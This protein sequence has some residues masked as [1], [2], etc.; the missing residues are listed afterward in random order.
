M[1]MCDRVVTCVEKKNRLAARR[2]RATS[3]TRCAGL[4]RAREWVLTPPARI[5]PP[6]RGNISMRHSTRHGLLGHFN[7]TPWRTHG[8][9]AGRQVRQRHGLLGAHVMDAERIGA[10]ARVHSQIVRSAIYRYDRTAVP[11]PL[12][13]IGRPARVS[14]MKSLSRS[15]RRAECAA[16]QTQSSVPRESTATYAANHHSNR[17][18]VLAHIRGVSRG[19]MQTRTPRQASMQSPP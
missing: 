9:N 8:R 16:R 4:H 2:R 15:G 12:I 14:P 19:T 5:G 17:R 13:R 1:R 6:C 11:S 10:Q 7:A 3:T 18:F